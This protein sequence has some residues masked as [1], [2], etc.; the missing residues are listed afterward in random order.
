MTRYDLSNALVLCAYCHT[1]GDG[2]V[3]R[4]AN[5]EKWVVRIIGQKEWN[6][7]ERLSVKYKS[8]DKARKEFLLCQI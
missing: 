5:Q 6:R 7:L 2:S 8:R 4:S 3:H 1:L